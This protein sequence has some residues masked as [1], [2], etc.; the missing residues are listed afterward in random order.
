MTIEGQTREFLLSSVKGWGGGVGR[1]CLNH[2]TVYLVLVVI[3]S[4]PVFMR[5]SDPARII[6]TY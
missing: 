2:P 5:E 3:D 6:N 1:H 4:D